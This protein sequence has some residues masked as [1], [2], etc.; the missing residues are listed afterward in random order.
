[1]KT[2]KIWLVFVR[3]FFGGYGV[4]VMAQDDMVFQYKGN[5][6]SMEK[7]GWVCNNRAVIGTDRLTLEQK[8][9]GAGL[10]AGSITSPVF[11]PHTGL[12]LEI[13]GKSSGDWNTTLNVKIISAVDQRVLKELNVQDVD[14]YGTSQVME[15]G[16]LV[17]RFTVVI[18]A[19]QYA[20]A[21]LVVTSLQMNGVSQSPEVSFSPETL[22]FG[23][24]KEG[25]SS[26]L[27]F[28]VETRKL[29][30]DLTLM[31]DNDAFDITPAK[32]LQDVST[33]VITVTF[34]PKAVTS[35]TGNIQVSGTDLD[36][37]YT[38]S[39]KGLSENSPVIYSSV[40]DLNFGA[41]SKGSSR[42]LSFYV[43]AENLAE[44]VMITADNSSFSVTP[45]VIPANLSEPQQITVVFA[46][47]T[48]NE[49][50]G[51]LSFVAFGLE[52]KI[53]LT[54]IGA[55]GGETPV[56]VENAIAEK[57]AKRI[58]GYYLGCI[59]STGLNEGYIQDR[60]IAIADSKDEV[61]NNRKHKIMVIELPA[62]STRNEWGSKSH[63]ELIG[64]QIWVEGNVGNDP[65]GKGCAAGF[66]ISGGDKIGFYVPVEIK[67]PQVEL[68]T[69]VLDFG[70]VACGESK[71]LQFSFT[72]TDLASGL[73][74]ISNYA[75]FSVDLSH[76]DQDS[77]E[78]QM[79]KVKF[80]PVRGGNATG[81][82]T[83][84]GDGINETVK[85]LGVG[86]AVMPPILME[87][88]IE[89]LVFEDVVAG[90]FEEQTFTVVFS[91]LSEDITV[92]C[93]NPI[94]EVNPSLIIVDGKS[95]QTVTVKFAPSSVQEY[96]ALLLLKSGEVEKTVA[97]R[98]KSVAAPSVDTDVAELDFGRVAIGDQPEKRRFI[99]DVANLKESVLLTSSDE[100][101]VLSKTEIP[102]DA[103]GEQEI[104][105]TFTP[106]E[107]GRISG[108]ILIYYGGEEVKSI[109][110]LAEAY[111][112]TVID[113]AGIT[114]LDFGSDLTTEP[115]SRSLKL[116]L[117][118][119][120]NDV[121]VTLEGE[122][123][124]LFAVSSSV[125]GRDEENGEKD[126]EITFTPESEGV[127]NATV[128]FSDGKGFS[129]EIALSAVVTSVSGIKGD[130]VSEKRP[131]G[132]N[133]NLYV[134]APRGTVVNVFTL[135]G[136]LVKM[137][138][139]TGREIVIPVPQKNVIVVVEN[140]AYKVSL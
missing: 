118:H 106:D 40:G 124:A 3:F 82:I 61:Y 108:E 12:S 81:F 54:G 35:Y 58:V 111:Y 99:L 66:K 117:L 137:I 42:Q 77:T 60:Y 122:D 7:D 87:T 79:V 21:P 43:T 91:G 31:C 34:S 53:S 84:K 78:P 47:D 11:G 129:Y 128:I 23:Y 139:A 132:F 2:F 68:S 100:C 51:E 85:V 120:E 119:M 25:E 57:G 95:E 52:K 116:S 134:S 83:I 102:V 30:S 90:Q 125:I 18:T 97:L 86:E 67:S 27:T 45:E 65:S 103:S 75:D 48:E 4:S 114:E 126:I 70:T 69:S 16:D 29:K 24:V 112:H 94:F 138:K 44:D 62:G 107:Q 39:G 33:T 131:Y 113:F 17:E 101:F 50:S 22:D 26:V 1:M 74:I 115:V 38:V 89:E 49:Y 105:V 140:K 133:G 136:T 36:V 88:S 13:F 72:P 9:T 121:T 64:R 59:T 8:A 56:S 63:P 135:K 14:K 96:T 130:S 73:D 110:L 5:F 104:I 109:D 46:P 32:I 28:E 6:S 20:Q 92:T 71:E 55:A 41:V 19:G 98:G 93:D 123:A 37:V 127:Y 80:T 15:I 76:V 10:D